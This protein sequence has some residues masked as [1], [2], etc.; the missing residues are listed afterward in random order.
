MIEQEACLVPELSQNTNRL[1]IAIAVRICKCDRFYPY[2][3]LEH[4]MSTKY[5]GTNPTD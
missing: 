3:V 4:P 1:Q 5:F 2:R